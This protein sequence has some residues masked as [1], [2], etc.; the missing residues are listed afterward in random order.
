MKL[1][2]SMSL[3]LVLALLS[4]SQLLKGSQHLLH[5]AAMEPAAAALTADLRQALQ[6]SLGD[7][8]TRG[9]PALEP[10]LLPQPA[11]PR[12]PFAFH[13][14]PAPQ[15][16]LP[17]PVPESEGNTLPPPIQTEPLRLKATAID[18]YG[19]L[20]FINDQVL[21]VGQSILGY[22]VVHIAAGQVELVREGK[23]LSLRVEDEYKP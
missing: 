5:N 3:S 11:L 2:I 12:D 23:T 16:E 14:P 9:L 22:T 10:A 13:A 17:Q 21:M 15:H 1:I 6:E 7:N 20:A 19:T 4:L 18:R 8:A